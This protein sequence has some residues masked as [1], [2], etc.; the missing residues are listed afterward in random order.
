VEV[1]VNPQIK[2]F[3]E[4]AGTLP[5]IPAVVSR[6]GEVISNEKSSASDVAKI[7]RTDP[8]LT[9]NILRVVNSA[10]YRGRHTV[11]S[12][13]DAVAR[14]G[15]RHVFEL[16]SGSWFRRALPTVLPLYNA[17]P[18]VFWLHSLGTAVFADRLIEK[19]SA[20][21][22][23]FFTAG[24]LH[25]VGMLVISIVLE[26]EHVVVAPIVAGTPI[27]EQERKALQVDHTEVGS[28]IAQTWRLPDA[29]GEAILRHHDPLSGDSHDARLAASIIHTASVTAYALGLGLDVTGLE[30]DVDPNVLD[31]LNISQVEVFKIAQEAMPEIQRMVS[32]L[33]VGGFR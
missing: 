21:N 7:I 8:G 15:M 18:D 14:L 33:V 11:V 22:P 4:R 31:A 17:R 13:D 24:L 26:K 28:A 32:A 19:M 2:R 27:C 29:I 23:A 10:V 25:H 20:P 3:V 12:V 5:G 1:P 6:L 30:R 9:G 16:A